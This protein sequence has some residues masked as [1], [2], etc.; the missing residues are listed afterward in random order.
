MEKRPPY[1]PWKALKNR[2]EALRA[3]R[4]NGIYFESKNNGHHIIVKYEKHVAD[5]W[6]SNGT[7]IIRGGDRGSGVQNLVNKLWRY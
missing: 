6:P 2:V 4:E 7:W 3:L 1:N 5:F